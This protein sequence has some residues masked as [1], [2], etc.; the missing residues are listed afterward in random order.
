MELSCLG[1]TCGSQGREPWVNFKLLPP[2]R[3]ER[4][5]QS[6]QISCR[7]TIVLHEHKGNITELS[8]FKSVLLQDVP[9]FM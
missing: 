5:R 8:F 4:P 2:S 3:R 1:E 9:R 7:S 6:V